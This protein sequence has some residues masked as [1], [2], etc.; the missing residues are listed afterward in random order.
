MTLFLRKSHKWIGLL[1]AIQFLLWM[2]SGVVMSLLDADK[3]EN[4]VRRLSKLQAEKFVP[5][6]K[7]LLFADGAFQ[8]DVTLT[9]KRVLTLTVGAEE[10]ASASAQSSELKGETV[11]IGGDLFTGPRGAPAYFSK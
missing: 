8:V 7:G 5:S 4:L 9:D 2:S 10:G 11:L 6:G 1:I 3:V